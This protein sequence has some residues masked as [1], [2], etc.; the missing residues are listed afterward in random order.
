MAKK[1]ERRRGREEGEGGVKGGG[2]RE[3][4]KEGEEGREGEPVTVLY[5]F[6]TNYSVIS[7]KLQVPR[8]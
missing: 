2:E 3:M 7:C 8:D 1:R 4:E 5:T 6:R